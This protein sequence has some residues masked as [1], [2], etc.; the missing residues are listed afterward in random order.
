MTKR[1]TA[2][3]PTQ[4]AANVSVLG[5][6]TRDGLSASNHNENALCFNCSRLLGAALSDALHA[7]TC[8]KTLDIERFMPPT[9][10][11]I[12]EAALREAAEHHR[13]MRQVDNRPSASGLTEVPR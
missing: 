3:R 6:Y 4:P 5:R 9:A 2:G 13:S 11:P 1:E 10:V 12:P 7:I 8:G